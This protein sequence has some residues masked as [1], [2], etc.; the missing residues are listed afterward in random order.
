MN[1]V[2]TH[3]H[4]SPT[5]SS[6]INI[7]SLYDYIIKID[8]VLFLEIQFI[9]HTDKHLIYITPHTSTQ[10]RLSHTYKAFTYIFTYT[11][12]YTRTYTHIYKMFWWFSIHLRTYI[13]M[14]VYTYIFVYMYTHIRCAFRFPGFWSSNLVELFQFVQS[15]STQSNT[16]AFNS[17]RGGHS[18]RILI[19]IARLTK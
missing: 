5:V 13:H 6:R 16:E 1:S 19:Y 7:I 11:H 9:I 14:R 3:T 10:V 15:D 18:L 12:V 4:T 2:Y 8:F 17:T